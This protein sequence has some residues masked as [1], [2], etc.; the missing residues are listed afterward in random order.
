MQNLQQKCNDDITPENTLQFNYSQLHSLTS[1]R[2][3]LTC[4][5]G[6]NTNIFIILAK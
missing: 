3:I 1:I 5:I 2:V 4:N 6:L